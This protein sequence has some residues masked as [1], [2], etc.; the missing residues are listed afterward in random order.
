MSHINYQINHVG[1]SDHE[2][3]FWWIHSTH[4]EK[5]D[6][7][8]FADLRSVSEQKSCLSLQ[9]V[10][11]ENEVK[12]HKRGEMFNQTSLMKNKID[13]ENLFFHISG[14]IVKNVHI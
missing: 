8:N 10:I 2:K 5:N 12:I 6:R 1:Y 3:N 9:V 13:I 7:L 4:I 11:Y 14:L